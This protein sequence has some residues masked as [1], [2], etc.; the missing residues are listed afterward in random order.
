[1]PS[2][3]LDTLIH[4]DH[5]C[6]K[7]IKDATMDVEG[8]PRNLGLGQYELAF[9]ENE[10][11]DEALPKL[12]AED[13]KQL[14]VTIVG[15]RRK[16]LA[17][18]GDLSGSPAPAAV[19][20]PAAAETPPR[21]DAAEGRQLTVMF[22]DLVGSTALA[23]RLDTSGMGDLIRAIQ[24]AVAA[25]GAVISGEVGHCGNAG[26]NPNFFEAPLTVGLPRLSVVPAPLGPTRAATARVDLSESAG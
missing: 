5:F 4:P 22:R 17:A 21:E 16:L 23:A 24:G 9:R 26:G 8:C 1:M 6:L 11:D 2:G 10:I 12:T 20:N 25:Y 19:I 14:G 13:L 18:I 15:D 7:P 3:A